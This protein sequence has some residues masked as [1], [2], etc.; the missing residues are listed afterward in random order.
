MRATVFEKA[1]IMKDP[2][3]GK[4][5]QTGDFSFFYKPNTGFRGKDLFVIYV[6]GS[7]AGASG[8]ARLTYNA[9]IR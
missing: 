4:I 6:C 7:S 1:I 9:T 5:T 8:C 3:N 2:A